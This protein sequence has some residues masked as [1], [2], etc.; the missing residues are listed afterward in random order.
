MCY[1]CRLRA[2]RLFR[3]PRGDADLRLL[4]ALLPPR[5]ARLRGFALL[6]LRTALF[7]AAL[8]RG[9]LPTFRDLAGDF[10]A[11]RR[12]DGLATALAVLTTLWTV[13]LVGTIARPLAAAFPASAPT[14]PPTTAPIG[15]ATLPTA[16]PATAPAVS[17]RI[18][19]ISM[20]SEDWGLSCFRESG[21]SGIN[22][23]A[24]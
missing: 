17:F 11:A 12:R 15:P 3:L 6:D 22:R 16:A 13:F 2:P 1:Q 24:P 18:G 14:T 20:F 23:E 10:F 4:L 5:P 8:P 9:A 7:L 19:G 21:S